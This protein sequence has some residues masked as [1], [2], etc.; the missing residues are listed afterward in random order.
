MPPASLPAQEQPA[1][2]DVVSSA[3]S[4]PLE[5]S[6]AVLLEPPVPLP[7]GATRETV[8]TPLHMF[9]AR[10]RVSW[11]AQAAAANYGLRTVRELYAWR[12]ARHGTRQ[13]PTLGLKRA[14]LKELHNAL[15]PG[16]F[17]AKRACSVTFFFK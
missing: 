3:E 11:A 12:D 13:R 1:A 9:F 15:D 2:A 5:S 4:I 17:D 7:S 14:Q 16:R 6:A 10:H 8:D